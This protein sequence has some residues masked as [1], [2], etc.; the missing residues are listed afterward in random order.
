[1]IGRLKMSFL[2]LAVG[3][4][5][6]VFSPLA[7]QDFDSRARLDEGPD[8]SLYYQQPTYGTS[9][10]A[11]I[12]QKAQARAHQRQ[13]RLATLSW[14]SMSTGRPAASSTPFTSY[15]S[16]ICTSPAGGPLSGNPAAGPPTPTSRA[17]AVNG[18]DGTSNP[19]AFCLRPGTG[20][21]APGALV[22]LS[23]G[24][25]GQQRSANRATL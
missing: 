4:T 18:R 10:R 15:Y 11:I 17:K 1:M 13:A 16:P 7:A 6:G 23:L 19:A 9:T 25:T 5:M 2:T 24:I 21:T 14:Y 22:E 20:L 8:E 12:Q 3:L